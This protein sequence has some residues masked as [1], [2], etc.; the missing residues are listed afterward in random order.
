MLVS[1]RWFG[2][3]APIEPVVGHNDLSVAL[4]HMGQYAPSTCL[5]VRVVDEQ[6]RPVPGAKVEFC[7]LNYGS[8]RTCA[9]LT[10]GTDPEEDCGVVRLDT[11]YGSLLV[12]AS[13]KGCYGETMAEL[14]GTK[15]AV[16][17]TVVLKER[18]SHLGEWRKMSLLA[19]REAV[20]DETKTQE[21][22]AKE[23]ARALQTAG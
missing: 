4:N 14:A 8:F 1:S 13:Q 9:M 16:T 22:A 23:A 15:E 5:T 17:C 10:T 19:P 2:K 6:G 3:D 12:C 7:L 18:L 11:G 20:R 21:Q